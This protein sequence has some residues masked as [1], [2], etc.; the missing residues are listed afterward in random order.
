MKNS[1]Y[2]T[3]GTPRSGWPG[4]SGVVEDHQKEAPSWEGRKTPLCFEVQTENELDDIIEKPD[5]QFAP[6]RI[7]TLRPSQFLPDPKHPRI[8]TERPAG[9]PAKPKF[10][11]PAQRLRGMISRKHVAVREYHRAKIGY[12]DYAD[13]K[14]ANA[15]IFQKID[16]ESFGKFNL[17]GVGDLKYSAGKRYGITMICT[18]KTSLNRKSKTTDRSWR[19]DSEHSFESQESYP[20]SNNGEVVGA[21]GNENRSTSVTASKQR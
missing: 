2:T 18:I 20:T 9:R 4:L 12:S 7:C 17:F 8:M 10:A 1:M 16:V 11:P 5:E 21:K 3:N 19:G 6:V 14:K 15:D 13:K